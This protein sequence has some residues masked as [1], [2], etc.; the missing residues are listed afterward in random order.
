MPRADIIADIVADPRRDRDNPRNDWPG[1][2]ARTT[3]A[4]VQARPGRAA[5]RRQGRHRRASRY[6]VPASHLFGP[7]E[8]PSL[9]GLEDA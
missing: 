2:A 6:E 3:L 9:P 8:E 4:G 1:H 7:S 5:R